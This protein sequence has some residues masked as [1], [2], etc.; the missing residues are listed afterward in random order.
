MPATYVPLRSYFAFNTARKDHDTSSTE[1][2][3][4]SLS[5]GKGYKMA[6]A[7]EVTNITIQFDVTGYTDRDTLIVKLYKN[8]SD[9]SK[10]IETASITGTGDYSGM[11]A[12]TA[13]SYSAGDTLS[14]YIAH[15]RGNVQTDN[16]SALIRIVEDVS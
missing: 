11:G 14:L 7:G 13:E 5:N 15:G 9:T 6:V 4:P 12:I 10:F 8:G 16:H 2:G 3:A 1:M